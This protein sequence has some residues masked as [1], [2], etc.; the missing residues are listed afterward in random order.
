MSQKSPS[1]QRRRKAHQQPP[2]PPPAARPPYTLCDP[3]FSRLKPQS[4]YWE[5]DLPEP[6]EQQTASPRLIR[7]S[8]LND[9]WMEIPRYEDR[10]SWWG[11]WVLLPFILLMIAFIYRDMTQ[12]EFDPSFSLVMFI[13]VSL[14]LYL[15][16][17]AVF[18]PR[19]TP[20]RLNRKRQKVYVYEHKRGWPWF[21]W[22]TTI[23]VFDW[24]DV[25]GELIRRSDI[26]VSGYELSC[27]VCK[28]GTY[29][30]VD[31]FSLN[32][33]GGSIPLKSVW[34]HCCMYMQGRRVPAAPVI[35]H[36]PASWTPVNTIRWPEALDRES[37]TA[38]G[39]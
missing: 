20:V 22:R 11:A 26:Y 18:A 31:R 35:R 13:A 5:E 9:T 25:H 3:G 10:I 8:E 19:G 27:A 33:Q 1:R 28:P 14:A 2:C 30:V 6:G 39:E 23:K 36:V 34:S 32:Y 21:P 24:A 4:D 38:P 37:T 7:V 17:M 12:P 15:F 16:R 29:E